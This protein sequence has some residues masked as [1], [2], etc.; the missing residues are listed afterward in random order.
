MIFPEPHFLTEQ[1]VKKMK[2][3]I[4]QSK[5]IFLSFS[6]LDLKFILREKEYVCMLLGGGRE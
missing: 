2:N 5:R 3:D 6:F 1:M 4:P